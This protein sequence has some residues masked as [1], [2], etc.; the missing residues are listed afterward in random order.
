MNNPIICALD[1]KDIVTAKILCAQV[2]D[3]VSMVKCGLEFFTKNGPGAINEISSLG[4]DVFLDLKFHDIPNT[5]DQAIRS[6]VSLN[7][8]MITIHT[9]GGKEMMQRAAEAAK[10][11]S[12][13]L[14][15]KT[16]LII[17]VTILTSMD[18]GDLQEININNRVKDQVKI[19]ALLAKESGLDGIVCSP[20][21]ITTVKEICGK[22]FKTIVPGIR[23]AITTSDDQKRV[24][25]AKQAV[26]KGAD[27]I[28]IGRPITKAEQPSI[29]ARNL[30]E[31]LR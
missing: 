15:V 10:D 28:V 7:V 29:A 19:L 3:Y 5:V 24:M 13:K 4:L 11:E 18:D 8:S 21:E 9:L 14:S 30:Y 31:S 20:H 16:P 26:D 25:T 2:K 12:A 27:Y 6:A 1:T 23:P 17:G 22:D